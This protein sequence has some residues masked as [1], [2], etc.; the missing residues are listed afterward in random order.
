MASKQHARNPGLEIGSCS[1]TNRPFRLCTIQVGKRRN[2]NKYI[3]SSTDQCAR[4]PATQLHSNSSTSMW[5][6]GNGSAKSHARGG[7]GK[8]KGKV[9][10]GKG[11]GPPTRGKTDRN[12]TQIIAEQ[13]Q[14]RH[15]VGQVARVNLS[16]R[17]DLCYSSLIVTNP[18]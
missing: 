13:K 16:K 8:G 5:L 18:P 6:T 10:S 11:K 17:A 15:G 12:I 1:A 9:G 14:Q 2:S 4:Y 7:K 3:S